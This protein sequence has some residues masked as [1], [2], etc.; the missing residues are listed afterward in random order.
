MRIWVLLVSLLAYPCWAEQPVSLYML[1]APPLTLIAPTDLV[2]KSKTLG[3][4]FA[5]D[6]SLMA[7]RRAGFRP[8]LVELPWRRAQDVVSTGKNLL[9]TPLSR[10]PTREAHY[11]WVAPLAPLNRVFVTLKSPINSYEEAR[12]SA[13]RIGVG[14][15]S[16]QYDLLLAQGFS[17][18]R[19]M[20]ANI[21]VTFAEMLAMGRIDSWFNGDAESLWF[22]RLSGNTLPLQIGN[23]VETSIL[24]LACSLECEADFKNRVALAVEQMRDSGEI[25]R[26]IAAYR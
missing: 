24:Y 25:D 22:W 19:I 10:I 6:I 11:Q 23:P 21:G 15:G 17:K 14:L 26:I 3:H 4:G 5:G 12:Q 2:D 13:G 9:I 20:A 16:A 7:L 8:Q 18:D 1:N